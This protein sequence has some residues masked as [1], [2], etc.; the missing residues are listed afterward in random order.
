MI[1]D[2][3]KSRRL[4]II[5][6]QSLEEGGDAVVGDFVR[7]I[8]GGQLGFV[9]HIS[10]NGWATVLMVNNAHGHREILEAKFLKRVSG[11]ST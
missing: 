10:P 6:A 11:M 1:M 7:P 2:R 5:R 4:L 9:Q 3:S 8:W